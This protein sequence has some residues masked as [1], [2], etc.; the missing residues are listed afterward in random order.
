MK[1]RLV[2]RRYRIKE[3]IGEGGIALVYRA[4]DEFTG[5][6]VALKEAHPGDESA[7][8]ALI[9]EFRF[10]S[11]YRHPTLV[12][13]EMMIHDSGRRYIVMPHLN[14]FDSGIIKD[15][16]YRSAEAPD[17]R[18]KAESVIA[19]ILECAA[20]IHFSRHI[21]ND[22]KPSNFMLAEKKT[23]GIDETHGIYLMDYNLVSPLD[24]KTAKRGTLEFTAPE[25]L[26]SGNS[27]T[28]KSDLYSIGAT[29]FTLLAGRPPFCSDQSS[30]LIKLI[31]ETGETD[32]SDIPESFRNGISAL[33]MRDPENRPANVA[34]AAEVLGVGD[35]FRHLRSIRTGCYLS[36][37]LPPFADMLKSSLADFERGGSGK[38]FMICGFDYGPDAV[39]YLASEKGLA[40]AEYYV[41]GHCLE[42][43]KN[44]A[45]LERLHKAVEASSDMKYLFIDNSALLDGNIGQKLRVSASGQK[46]LTIIAAVRKWRKIEMP[47]V[48]FDP[49]AGHTGC[50]AA[51][52]CLKAFLKRETINFGYEHLAEA[53]GGIPEFIYYHLI[54][55]TASGKLDLFS[56]I[57]ELPDNNS[58]ELAPEIAAS[59]ERMTDILTARE[60]SMLSKLS[61][62]GNSVPMLLFVE[63]EED[64][65]K[66]IDDLLTSGHLIRS[67]DAV[68]FPAG[69][70]KDCV[71]S[72]IPPTERKKYHRY[73]AETAEKHLLDSDF[74][75]ELSA[76]HWG[77]SNDLKRGYQT[78]REAAEEY[79]RQGNIS[80]ALGFART[81]LELA[82]KGGGPKAAALMIY[83]DIAKG[84]GDY[85][86]AR[87]KYIE[88]LTILRT[89]NDVNLKAKTLK[90]LGDLYRSLRKT[91]KALYYTRRAMGYYKGLSDKQGV[92]SCLNNLGLTLWVNEEFS[93]ALE[94]FEEANKINLV[95]ENFR[96]LAK[97]QSNMG[98]INDI[99]GSGSAARAHFVSALDYARQAKNP[100]L[101]ALILN[102][103][104][105]ACLR[106]ADMSVSK[107]YLEEALKISER[108][109]FTEEVI[110]S[111][112]NLGLYHLRRG[113]LFSSADYNQKAREMA[114]SFG[115]RHLMAES[116]LHLAEVCTLMGNFALANE[117]ILSIEDDT[118]Y[119]T[120]RSLRS[121]TDL[122]RSG[123]CLAV[124]EYKRSRDLAQGVF[125][126]AQASGDSRLKLEARLAATESGWGIKMEEA[127][128]NLSGIVAEAGKL[129]HQDLVESSSMLLANIY[130]EKNDN[131]SAEGWIERTLLSESQPRKIQIEAVLVRSTIQFRLGKYDQ[132]LDGLKTIESIAGASG[133]IPLAYRASVLIAMIYLSC[134][135]IE[136]AQAAADRAYS[137]RD[138]LISSL[139]DGFPINQFLTMPAMANLNKISIE[140]K[141]KEFIRI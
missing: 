10:G 79:L 43:E 116:E 72:K 128:K 81:L 73:W 98:I 108:I 110:N 30:D 35:Q 34:E 4:E 70:L 26:K 45:I 14:G 113:D 52:V 91:E 138:K 68:S 49:L 85:Q 58:Y 123:W 76:R 136:D 7:E 107:D 99:I 23:P 84:E 137:Y 75:L 127:L 55:A 54:S 50:Y 134:L 64:E 109:G 60:F 51:G 140:L 93:K 69:D 104:G 29:L 65:Q 103:L 141:N 122:H 44:A 135:K 90:D 66:I 88:L 21:Y 95:L 92:A 83:A 112:S 80:R 56:D 1:H 22:F 32:Y 28:V 114:G 86:E 8:Q 100:R 132:A 120:D 106:Q 46:N 129:G 131:F 57:I 102:N 62:W 48:L 124:G 6:I 16:Y 61:V 71:Y 67:R 47:Y 121:Q 115:N 3:L 59:A 63:F 119:R 105:Y 77:K 5:E 9:H 117:V 25:I 27:P 53:S 36:S 126:D 11:R 24:E 2:G 20:F 33:L 37:G 139:P 39:N 118:L 19:E 41:V 42:E 38:I 130:L 74:S 94:S 87:D 111:L 31:T 133:F 97:I 12:P 101:E 78:N 40:G 17:I 89:E 125:N 96:E 13:H 15:I 82:E 18:L